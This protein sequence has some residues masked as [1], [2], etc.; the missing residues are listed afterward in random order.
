MEIVK[1]TKALLLL[2]LQA[3]AKPDDQEKPEVLLVRAGFNA[4]EI[5]DL[6][7]KRDAAVRKSI[8]RAGK[9]A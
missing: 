4:R 7:G 5:A 1:A 2:Q 8:Q 6:L 9:A 3:Q